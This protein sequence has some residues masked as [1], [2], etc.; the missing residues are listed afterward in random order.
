MKAWTVE[1]FGPYREALQL[2]EQPAPEPHGTAS[3]IDVKAAGV[4]FA[5][6]LNISGQYQMKAPLPFVPGSE[7]AGVV[8]AAGEH[9]PFKPGDR[10]AALNLMGAFAGQMLALDTFTFRIPDSMSFEQAAAF[11][12]N[13]QTAYFGIIRRGRLQAGE[14]LLVHGGA[15]GAGTAAIHMGK[16]FGATVIAT[17]GNPDKL[18]VCTRCG[19]DYVINYRE[20][21]F[22]ASVRELTG[23]KGADVIFDPVGGDVFDQSL[24]CINV[25]GRIIVIG[26]ASG[27][28]PDLAMNRVLLKNIDVVGLF[29]GNYQIAAPELIQQAQHELYALFEAGQLVPH[30]GASY[31]FEQLPEALASIEARKATGKVVLLT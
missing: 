10:V 24:K 29:W 18:A 28:I 16:A 27:R 3:V 2:S 15:G 20:D 1:A 17:A 30:I 25:E 31:P 22:V 11:T 13:Y 19:A 23:G 9:A 6:L 12:I 4:M 26:F 14:T 8:A 5:D 7:A 21:N